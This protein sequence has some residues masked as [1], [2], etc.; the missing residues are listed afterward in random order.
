MEFIYRRNSA[1]LE[2]LES[3]RLFSAAP[4]LNLLFFGNSFTN[5]TTDGAA[6]DMP[7]TLK[8]IAV[9]D[10]PAAPN[11]FEQILSGKNLG[12][13]LVTIDPSGATNLTVTTQTVTL[14]NLTNVSA[15]SP[16]AAH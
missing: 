12:D 10:G 16:P 9:A 4:A 15:V 5:N 8:A 13:H 11:V 7:A 14:R 1:L 3:R 2:S 6:Y